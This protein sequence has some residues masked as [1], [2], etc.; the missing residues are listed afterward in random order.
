MRAIIATA[1]LALLA[2]PG[3]AAASAAAPTNCKAAGARYE[4][5]GAPGLTAG[6]RPMASHT[7]W[8]TDVA[9]FVHSDHSKKTFW[10]LFDAGTARYINL[11][12]TTD[13]TQTSWTPPP[14]DGGDRALG[15]M[16]YMAADAALKFSLEL[17]R[18]TTTPPAYILLPDLSEKLRYGQAGGDREDVPVAFFKLKGC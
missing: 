1:A 11:I 4:M 9:F 18:Q 7:G 10:F 16:H 12:S 6:F 14:P 15:E 2:I 8:L 17:P 5:M 13:V 3:L